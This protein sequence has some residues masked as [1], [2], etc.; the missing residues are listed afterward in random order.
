MRDNWAV[1]EMGSRVG[2]QPIYVYV[3]RS[4]ANVR[5]SVLYRIYKNGTLLDTIRIDQQAQKGWIL[6]GA[7]NFRGAEVRVEA[8]DNETLEHYNRNRPSD[9]RIGVDAMAMR[10]WTRCW[11]TGELPPE[12]ETY[13]L[14]D[15]I[16][17]V[18]E[19]GKNG[20]LCNR[21]ATYRPP[22]RVDPWNALIGECTS[23]V[24]FRLNAA[25]IPMH[26][27]AGG[28]FTPRKTPKCTTGWSNAHCWDDRARD[29]NSRRTE[30]AGFTVRISDAPAV[31]AVAQWNW[32]P[33]GHIAYVEEVRDNGNTIVVSEMNYGNW[34]D[35]RR[36]EWCKLGTRTIRL[37]DAEHASV[38]RRW[39][40]NFI[41]F[42]T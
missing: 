41:H 32:S 26:N 37:E 1:W 30:S 22:S 7:W 20:S 3:P 38:W 35:G 39:P 10:C 2:R 27:G 40:D 12:P 14:D 34:R 19:G 16:Q 13:S 33:L 6:L 9:S 29:W 31:G 21:P 25:G 36:L 17:A 28:T 23:W 5:A 42:E 11:D 4:P 15:Y 24:M 8:W 18:N